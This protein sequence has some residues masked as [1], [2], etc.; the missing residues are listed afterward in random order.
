ML[1]HCLS[2]LTFR[3]ESRHKNTRTRKE[4]TELPGNAT[5]PPAVAAVIAQISWCVCVRVL[6]IF[7]VLDGKT[8]TKN[9]TIYF[10]FWLDFLF[11]FCCIKVHC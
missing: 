5:D 7:D 8:I 4:S 1:T 2:C 9:R 3:K 11:Q 6:I 10:S